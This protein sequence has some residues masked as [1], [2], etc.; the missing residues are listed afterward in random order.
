M[1]TPQQAARQALIALLV[2]CACGLLHGFLRPV[3]RKHPHLADLVFGAGL[4][5]AWLY[6][7]FAVCAGDL[8]LGYTGALFAGTVLWELSF[9]RLLRPLFTGIW[10]FF[11]RL[12]RFAASP[13]VKTAKKQEKL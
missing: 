1:S 5:W 10:R 8:R 13:F 4:L 7:G 3:G 9:G 6:V 2:G 12:F 11:A